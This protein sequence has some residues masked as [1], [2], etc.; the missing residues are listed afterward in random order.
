MITREYLTGR[1]GAEIEVED[2]VKG[3]HLEG[4]IRKIALIQST[5]RP[6]PSSFMKMIS[7]VTN[8]LLDVED[9]IAWVQAG[10][11]LGE[12]YYR[13]SEKSS[14]FGFPAGFCY[15]LGV[16][17]HFSRGG[18]GNLMRKYGLAADNF[19]DAHIVDVKGRFLNRKS[20]GEDLFWPIR[21]GGAES[22]GVV[23]A[24]GFIMVE[25]KIEAYDGLIGGAYDCKQ[26]L[27]RKERKEEQ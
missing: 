14:I 3:V 15:T 11:T 13:I 23:F 10:V 24:W 2:S 18:F 22:F 4:Q 6:I 9:K 27:P 26:K 19:L 20:M 8:R 7:L 17:G 1:R 12:V 25:C 21:G 16:G 5:Y